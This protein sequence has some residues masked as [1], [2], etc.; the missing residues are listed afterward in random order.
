MNFQCYLP[1]ANKFTVHSGGMALPMINI[2]SSS[3]KALQYALTIFF[4]SFPVFFHSDEIQIPVRF[5]PYLTDIFRIEFSHEEMSPCVLILTL[6]GIYP[7][8][9]DI[10]GSNCQFKNGIVIN[11]LRHQLSCSL[12][13]SYLV[14]H[15]VCP[16]FFHKSIQT[17]SMACAIFI[18]IS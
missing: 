11:L 13:Q 17:A 4:F 15:F 2:I 7:T 16:S 6:K 10:K 1:S 9:L 18:I 5:L 3:G 14:L 12:G 8:T